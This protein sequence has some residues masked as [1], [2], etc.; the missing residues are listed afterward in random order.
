VKRHLSLG[1]IGHVDHGKTALVRALTGIETD[2]LEEER[3]RGLSIV[4][5]F[6]H[7][8]L[9]GG[10]VDFIDVPG[11]EDFVRTMIAGATGIDG[12]LLI[13]AANETVMPQTREHFAIAK[14]LGIDRGLVVV[15]K[16][17]L[18]SEDDL[19]LAAQRVRELVSGSG[20]EDAP[21]VNVS[22]V[23]G[24]GI[25]AL[26]AQIEALLVPED[27]A[28]LRDDAFLPIDR[29]FA[30]QGF[31]VVVTGTLKHGRLREDQA[32]ELL[33]R[34]RDATIRA[35]QAHRQPISVAEP[36]QRVAVNLRGVRREEIDRGDVL[37]SK[38]FLTPTRRLDVELEL[39][40][41]TAAA[42]K[43][44]AAV[45]VLVGTSEVI[46]R[47]R[48][49]GHRAL[50]PGERGYA[51]LRCDTDVVTHRDERFIVRSVSPIATIGGGRVLVAGAERHRRFDADTLAQL[52]RVAATD[53]QA[54]FEA[55]LA[56][57]GIAG[58]ELRDVRQELGLSSQALSAAVECADAERIGDTR[59][60]HSKVY[61]ALLADIISAVERFHSAQP[62]K[63][64]LAAGALPHELDR[65]CDSKVLQHAVAEL[66]SAG[67]LA[68]EGGALRLPQ[69]DPL[70]GLP[71]EE[72]ELAAKIEQ[73][74]RSGG[75]ATP[76]IDSVVDKNPATRQLLQLLLDTGRLVR[77]KTYDR[78]SRMVLH[79]D[80]LTTVTQRLQQQFPHPDTFTVADVRDLLNATRKSIV[81]LM[82]HLDSTGA[83]I[84]DG[85]VRRLRVH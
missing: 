6:A 83:T 2:R 21:V 85:N 61:A 24:E 14:L 31:G 3:Q 35:L 34:G 29:V 71:V 13:V 28:D 36:G 23:T 43:N 41:D 69:F 9:D 77:L 68:A 73:L 48:L 5:G 40:S 18:V 64:G 67:E 56:D 72:R 57:A 10:I 32:V 55:R 65:D 60:V 63:A 38:A 62:K 44:G 78:K 47:V 52:E 50:E 74:F 11:H 1:V 26:L 8:E 84:R 27:P 15:T 20:L 81:P 51:Q 7:V 59:V 45:R 54:V 75:L 39:L 17:D 82:E 22:S 79:S 25:Q 37:A 76:D 70:G 53:A 33:P 19:T 80:V 49:L 30:M 12:V 42:L 66:V 58:L 16:T 4:L 46:A